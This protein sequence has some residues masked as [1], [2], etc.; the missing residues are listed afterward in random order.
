M[1]SHSE[2]YSPA[3][4]LVNLQKFSGS[5]CASIVVMVKCVENALH[6]SKKLYSYG[7]LN[8]II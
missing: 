3:F 4:T 1:T 6:A 2:T 7:I 8:E 5:T